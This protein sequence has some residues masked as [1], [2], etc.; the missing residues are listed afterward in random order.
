MKQE[1]CVIWL[2]RD[3]RTK[4]H[5]SFYQARK[6]KLPLIVLYCFEPTVSHSADWDERHWRFIYQSLMDLNGKIPV[7]WTHGEVVQTLDEIQKKFTVKFI[8]SHQES[9]TEAT[10]KRDKEVSRWCQRNGTSWKQHQSNG[11]VRALKNNKEWERLWASTMKRDLLSVDLSQL[12]FAD[13]SGLELNHDLSESITSVHSSFLKGGEEEALINMANF[14][15]TFDFEKNNYTPSQGHYTTSSLSPYISW[16]NL[17][18]RQVYQ[19]ALKL[20]PANTDKKNILQ[21]INRLKWHCHFIQKFEEDTDLEFG[22]DG[23][24]L[25]KELFRAWKM[26]LTGYPLMDACMRCVRETGHLNYRMR[27]LVVS[28]LSHYLN[29]PWEEG[30]KYLARQFLDYEPGI[31]YPQ[32]HLQSEA[33]HNP[34]KQSRDKDQEAE[35][36]RK[37]VPELRETPLKLIHRPWEINDPSYP[38]PVVML[39]DGVS[40]K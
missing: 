4:D 21:F 33:I 35:F 28:F 12:S 13:V 20:I 10:Y 14:F 6:S 26:G 39:K 18:L 15:R 24:K 37:W 34:V 2:K 19:E 22:R 11:V 5:S 9:G 38:F 40:K 31:H 17:S 25:D 23:K 32:F 1:V 30:A 3:L 7:T 29:Q 27:S 8:H 36:I 16:G